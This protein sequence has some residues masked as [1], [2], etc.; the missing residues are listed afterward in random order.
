MAKGRVKTQN[1]ASQRQKKKSQ[2]KRKLKLIKPGYG[3]LPDLPDHGIF[4]LN[5]LDQS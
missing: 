4:C 1:L 5:K 2:G 3:W